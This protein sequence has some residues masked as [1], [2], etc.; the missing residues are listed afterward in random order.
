MQRGTFLLLLD[1]Y[2]VFLSTEHLITCQATKPRTQR[3]ISWFLPLKNSQKEFF[4]KEYKNI[5]AM[6]STILQMC[7]TY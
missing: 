6:G 2:L 4:K 3:G 1:K 5:Y 7:S